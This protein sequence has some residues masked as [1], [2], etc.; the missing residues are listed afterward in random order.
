MQKTLDFTPRDYQK[1]ALAH[2]MDN[3]RCA[4]WASMGMGK[5]TVCLTAINMLQLLDDAPALVL[6]PKRVAATTWPEEAAK[7]TH[8]AH[9]TV[10]PILGN[11]KQREAA[12][13]I[14]SDVYTMNYENI[15]WLVEH[16]GNAWPFKTVVA[17]ESTRLK[18]YRSRGGSKRARA[19]AKIAHKKIDRFIELTGT[20][21]PNGLIDLWGQ[22][23][24]LDGGKRLGYSF[25]AFQ[26][27]WF[28][29]TQ[30]GAQRFAV[31]LDPL[32]F[33]QKQIQNSLKDVCLTL[34][35]HDYFDIEQPIVNNVI[36]DLD[37]KSRKLYDMMQKEMFFELGG[38]DIEAMNAAA[39]TVKCL[40]LANG[41]V[42]N[43]DGEWHDVHDA[44]IQ[45]LDSI[46]EESAGM[47][48][49]VAYHFKSDLAR[50]KKAFKQGRVLDSDPNTIKEWNEGKI[51]VLFAHPA[52][53]GHGLNLQH[54][55]NIL[56]VFG[57]WWNL[58]EYQQIVE[59]IGP[60]R[61]AQAGYKRPVYIYHIIAKDT[62]DELVM[63]RREGKKTVQEILLN[64]MKRGAKC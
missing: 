44:K 19:L 5:T 22:A 17:D 59:R 29:T 16:F 4:L 13:A 32:D 3:D 61:Q 53:A 10:T 47:P 35:A 41:S 23:F 49:L 60:T 27:R 33:A 48:I 31:R 38:D 64:A 39:K 45:A 40:Q 20:P 42:Y 57:H 15:P 7:W 25:S 63:E 34:D 8:L 11:A 12:L 30:V 1:I 21:S 56:V 2:I 46:I 54:G 37:D 28:K 62:V 24:F 50:L 55:G 58:E 43:A 9:L 51:P 26:N 14:K 18:S 6:A 52:S 36:V